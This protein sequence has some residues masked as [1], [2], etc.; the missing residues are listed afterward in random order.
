MDV[1]VQLTYHFFG[2][3]AN[4]NLI[5]QWDVLLLCWK[6]S[7]KI[8]CWYCNIYI[9]LW[10]NYWWLPFKVWHRSIS[11]PLCAYQQRQTAHIVRD[12]CHVFPVTQ[13]QTCEETQE[14]TRCFQDL[15]GEQRGRKS[16]F[17]VK[18]PGWSLNTSPLSILLVHVC[19]GS[20][21]SGSTRGRCSWVGG[22]S[23]WVSSASWLSSKRQS[24]RSLLEERFKRSSRSQQQVQSPQ[25]SWFYLSVHVLDNAW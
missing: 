22:N 23:T 1:R 2:N 20:H 8:N 3:V 14:K 17:G 12:G 21:S 15:P 24:W 10:L 9:T 6:K 7:K 18:P 11:I 13:I 5:I 16:G 25:F 4:W 19:E